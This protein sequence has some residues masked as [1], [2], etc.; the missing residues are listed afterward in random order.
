[1]L[2]KLIILILFIAITAIAIGFVTIPAFG[3][4]TTFKMPGNNDYLEKDAFT[5]ATVIEVPIA[6]QFFGAEKLQIVIGFDESGTGYTEIIGD[7]KQD[8]NTYKYA[9]TQKEVS[10]KDYVYI[11]PVAVLFWIFFLL[12]I[13]LLPRKHGKKKIKK[14]ATQVAE[15][16]CYDEMQNM[17][18]S[19]SY[20]PAPRRRDDREAP[21]GEGRRRRDD[22]DDDY[23]Y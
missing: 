12:M 16:V 8:D 3:L 6:A 23:D 1:M 13:I 9:F 15:D 21:R 2:K 20:A 10:E 14:L 22:Y 4:A 19:R 17:A 11:S 7:V 18:P 5:S